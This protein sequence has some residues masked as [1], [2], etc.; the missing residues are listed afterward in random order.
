[1]RC[2]PSMVVCLVLWSGYAGAAELRYVDTIPVHA[3]IVVVDTRALQT[4]LRAT[5]AGAHCLPATDLIGPQGQLPNFADLSWALGTAGLS[6]RETVLV[7]GARSERR[8]F[9]AG[10]LYLAGQRRVDILTTP[11]ARL[12][13][14]GHLDTGPGR[15]RGMLSDPIYTATMRDRLIDLAADLKRALRAHA[16][17]VAVDGRPSSDYRRLGHV[18]GALNLPL[19]RVDVRSVRARLLDGAPSAS[20]RHY[21]AYGAG[22]MDSIALFTRLR[23]AGVPAR[24]L[25]G[26]WRAWAGAPGIG[27]HGASLPAHA[28]KTESGAPAATAWV[29]AAGVVMI[30]GALLLFAMAFAKRKGQ[31]WM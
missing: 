26:G 15:A 14:A 11:L 30:A 31:R 29:R 21:V 27:G 17:V 4:C 13:A 1:M 24:V 25:I 16:D 12:L 23:A 2:A 28:V 9:V 20:A 5:I 6:G 7:A 18:P 19:S 10:L 8:D 3:G 22:P